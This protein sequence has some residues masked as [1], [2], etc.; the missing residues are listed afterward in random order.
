PP[1]PTI[2]RISGH[3]VERS[4]EPVAGANVVLRRLMP[5]KTGDEHGQFL[6]GASIPTGADG[7]FSFARVSQWAHSL[8][9]RRDWLKQP[10]EIALASAADLRDLRIV[11][12]ALTY[13]KVDL[14][15][16]TVTA[17]QFAVLDASDCEMTFLFATADGSYSTKRQVLI[18]GKS[19]AL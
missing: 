6:Y 19:R 4:G 14:G 15:D 11:L 5:A 17:N 8:V 12:P 13:L 10:V 18:D 1:E 7:G 2:E 3:V 16:S 9:V